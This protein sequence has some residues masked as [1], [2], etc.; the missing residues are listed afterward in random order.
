MRRLHTHTLTSMSDTHT[1]NP[2]P[3]RP[4]Q[5]SAP[6]EAVWRAV[7]RWGQ[8]H[9]GVEPGRALAWSEEEKQRMRDSLEGEGVWSAARVS[10]VRK[11]AE[12]MWCVFGASLGGA[13]LACRCAGV[14]AGDGDQQ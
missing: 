3:S 5:L 14:C 8:E 10:E 4:H 7:L 6:E 9:S 12:G 2:T 1:C 11:G 13:C